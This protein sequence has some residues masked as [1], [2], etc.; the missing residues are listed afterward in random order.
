[1][2]ATIRRLLT[3]LK[4]QFHCGLVL[5]SNLAKQAAIVYCKQAG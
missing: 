5:P 1:M 4:D 2:N 3:D